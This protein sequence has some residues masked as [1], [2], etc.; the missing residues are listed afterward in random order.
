MGTFFLSHPFSPVFPGSSPLVL[1]TPW[2]DPNYLSPPVIR[3]QRFFLL[4][5]SSD[6]FSFSSLIFT[7]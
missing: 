7:G 3:Y 4:Y 2:F 5:T 6:F 1:Y